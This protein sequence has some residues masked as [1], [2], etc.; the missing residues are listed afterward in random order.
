[1][2]SELELAKRFLDVIPPL[3]HELRT[4]VRSAALD[5]LTVPQFRILANIHR[6]L[7]HVGEIADHHGVSQPAM[8]KMVDKL[9]NQGLIKR[10]THESDRRHFVLSL[11]AK[12]VSL[13]QEVKKQ[14]QDQ[15]GLKLKGLSQKER[16]ELIK[17]LEQI[18]S[19]FLRKTKK[20]ERPYENH[21]SVTAR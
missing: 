10:V 5:R 20:K 13:Y 8:S 14:A 21:E 7:C 11:T 12:G 3:M 6:G 1:M 17:S 16:G 9:V 18:E 2:G 15:L 4:E 19:L